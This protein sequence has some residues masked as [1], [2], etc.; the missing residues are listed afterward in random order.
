[1]VKITIRK[2]S[3]ST[4][5]GYSLVSPLTFEFVVHSKH[6]HDIICAYRSVQNI[7]LFWLSKEI[8]EMRYKNNQINDGLY[9]R[10]DSEKIE[11]V[12]NYDIVLARIT[13]KTP[14]NLGLG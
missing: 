12:G 5:A 9:I 6:Y 13:F 7:P 2:I 8:L 1:M 4:D 14:L 11:F 10:Y 3:T